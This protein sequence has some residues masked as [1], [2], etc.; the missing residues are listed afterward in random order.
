MTDDER[1]EHLRRKLEELG[2][3]RREQVAD[4][5]AAADGSNPERARA[6]TERLARRDR[7]A[8]ERLAHEHRER[9][10]L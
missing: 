4:L 5:A 2:R 9:G 6:A 7:D 10:R 8:A 1:R 3:Q